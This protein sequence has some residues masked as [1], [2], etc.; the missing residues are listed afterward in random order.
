MKDLLIGVLC[1]CLA[2]FNFALGESNFEHSPLF[3][4]FSIVVGLICCG[5]AWFSFRLVYLTFGG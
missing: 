3:G 2:N 1:V 5:G 4:M